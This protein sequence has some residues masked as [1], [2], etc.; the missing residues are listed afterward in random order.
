MTRRRTQPL[1]PHEIISNLRSSQESTEIEHMIHST[2][3]TGNTIGSSQTSV[4]C[5]SEQR[6]T[7]N[8]SIDR[9]PSPPASNP[10]IILSPKPEELKKIRKPA[11]PE[12]QREKPLTNDGTLSGSQQQVTEE[13]VLAKDTQHQPSQRS[14]AI[15]EEGPE[16]DVVDSS[17]EPATRCNDQ[18]SHSEQPLADIRTP[19]EELPPIPNLHRTSSS[20]RLAMSLDGTAKVVVGSDSP[21]PPRKPLAPLRLPKQAMT[22]QRSRSLLEPKTQTS[23]DLATRF[24]SWPRHRVAGRSRDARTWEFYCDSE[25]RN[26]LTVQAEQDQKG[27]AV[28][29]LGLIRSESANNKVLMPSLNKHNSQLKKHDSM[30][31]KVAAASHDQKPKLARTTSSVARLQTV[32]G[33]IQPKVQEA[34]EKS[35]KA[36]SQITLYRDPSGDSDKENWVP[37]TQT[38]NIRRRQQNAQSLSST[39]RTILGENSSV[40]SH[41]TN[42][43][44][45]QGQS[46]TIQRRREKRKSDTQDKENVEVD[47]EVSQFMGG[48]SLPREEEELDCVQGLLSLSQGAWR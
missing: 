24:P 35:F 26:A 41:A 21:S 8:K 3:E 17:R 33:N 48:S 10:E 36:N 13:I 1:L 15:P 27:S 12:S 20:V 29:I 42:F 14:M 16:S 9:G 11:L 2:A 31:R 6:T 44:S 47:E 45:V 34:K 28:G 23:E 39:R 37:G 46:N 30:K 18:S 38:T 25:A 32:S 7:G 43:G 5:S 22:L 40:V 19:W 4:S